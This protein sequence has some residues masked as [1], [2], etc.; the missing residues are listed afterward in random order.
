MNT[1]LSR[2]NFAQLLGGAAAAAT[3]PS[4]AVK[5]LFAATP[6]TGPIRLSANENPYGPSPLAKEAMRAAMDIGQDFEMA[7]PSPNPPARL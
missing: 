4:F 5:P 6:A 1:S 7:R 2:R 3:L